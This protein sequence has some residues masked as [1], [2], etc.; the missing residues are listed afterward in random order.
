MTDFTGT[1]GHENRLMSPSFYA[2]LVHGD[3]EAETFV[4]F[5]T[6]EGQE[7]SPVC[8]AAVSLLISSLNDAHGI[9]TVYETT[10]D[11]YQGVI[12]GFAFLES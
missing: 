9:R 3:H 1:S 8:R 7:A 4:K 12:Y 5:D 2:C 10:V 11:A 6:S